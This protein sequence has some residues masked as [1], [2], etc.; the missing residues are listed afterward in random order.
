MPPQTI[1]DYVRD[2]NADMVQS[3][4]Q[5]TNRIQGV[6]LN[7]LLTFAVN[8]GQ[9]KVVM[10]LLD[11]LRVDPSYENNWTI[12]MASMFGMVDVVKRLLEDSRVDPRV[13]NN[14]PIL[15]AFQ[16]N[17]PEV[18]EVLLNDP[19]V[20]PSV[21]TSNNGRFLMALRM[22]YSDRDEK[23]YTQIIDIFKRVAM[24]SKLKLARKVKALLDNGESSQILARLKREGIPSVF[25]FSFIDATCKYTGSDE[26]IERLVVQIIEYVTSIHNQSA[27]HTSKHKYNDTMGY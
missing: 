23:P 1:Y 26:K 10:T 4:L 19:R 8:N 24:E 22:L 12:K 14:D 5:D 21:I 11:D 16:C 27:N 7:K 13:D 25:K 2:G 20:D 17:Q 6:D 3:L 18:A 15:N 9:E